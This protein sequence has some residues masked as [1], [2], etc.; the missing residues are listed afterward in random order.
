MLKTYLRKRQ[1]ASRYQTTDRNV[2][3]M[4]RDGRIPPP[5]F[6]NGRFPLWDAAKLDA[7][8]HAAAAR[9]QGRRTERGATAVVDTA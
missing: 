2:D 5:D 7:N 3:R 1:V 4:A 9:R 6:Y 8:D